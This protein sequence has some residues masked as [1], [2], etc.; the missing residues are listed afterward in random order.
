MLGRCAGPPLHPHHSPLVPPTLPGSGPTSS[1]F[2]RSRSV[3]SLKE[4]LWL[5][6]YY[7]EKDDLLSEAGWTGHCKPADSVLSL[8]CFHLAIWIKSRL[9]FQ[10]S[11]GNSFSSSKTFQCVSKLLASGLGPCGHPVPINAYGDFGA[12]CNQLYCRSGWYTTFAGDAIGK[13]RRSD[14]S[15][16]HYVVYT[17]NIQLNKV[18]NTSLW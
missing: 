16:M 12:V 7:P 5:E 9:L 18:I 17:D 14:C 13:V 3:P 8:S 15:N 4:R 2:S 1:T 11:E 6:K 10:V